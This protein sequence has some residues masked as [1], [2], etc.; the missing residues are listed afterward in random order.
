MLVYINIPQNQHDKDGN[1]CRNFTISP[2]A[3]SLQM[4]LNGHRGHRGVSVPVNA[5]WD[6]K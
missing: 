5:V 6:T 4:H 2:H 3:S 1:H